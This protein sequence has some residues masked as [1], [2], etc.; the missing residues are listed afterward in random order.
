MVHL[1]KL[2]MA[3]QVLTPS[4]QSH[5]RE[6]WSAEIA[7]GLRAILFKLS[8]WDHNT[9]YGAALQNLRYADSRTSRQTYAAP[10]RWQKGL[11]G[12]FAVGGRYAWVKWEDWLSARE[13]TINEV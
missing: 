12:L 2:D 9:T 8:I 4:A 13:N 3:V 5:F 10:S 1:Y 11:Y 6:D 7:L